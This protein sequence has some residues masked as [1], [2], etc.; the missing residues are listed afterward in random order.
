MLVSIKRKTKKPFRNKPRQT[1][2]KASFQKSIKTIK[3]IKIIRER[4]NTSC[5]W[6]KR[7]NNVKMSVL[8]KLIY[9]INSDFPSPHFWFCLGFFCEKFQT[10]RQKTQR[11]KIL[12]KGGQKDKE[13]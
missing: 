13:E 1:I 3:A 4:G 8:P 2:Y 6:M 7:F 12:L 9:R 10:D 5:V 11:I